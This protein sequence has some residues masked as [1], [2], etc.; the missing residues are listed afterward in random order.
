[1]S[2]LKLL[3]QGAEASVFLNSEKK[4][5][6]KKRLPKSYRLKVLD[7]KLRR[8]RTRAE[9][10][11]LRRLSSV[12]GIS[13]PSLLSFSEKEGELVMSFVEGM[14][15]SEGLKD[16]SLAEA[17]VVCGSIGRAVSAMH[18]SNV[19]HG[20]LTTSNMILDNV[21]VVWFV[22]FGLGFYS[23]K[24]EDKAVDIHLFHEALEAKHF[25]NSKSL[26]KA[27]LQSYKI[28]VNYDS[29]MLQLKKVEGRGRYRH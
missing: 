13:V 12:E 10:N 9:S 5:V 18:D 27:F 11:M 4:T 28:S 24:F 2:N 3:Y 8:L 20:D 19:V 14:K 26:W 23:E 15:L 6:I 17:R 7:D 21:G 16:L 22:D 1:M 29:T 25:A